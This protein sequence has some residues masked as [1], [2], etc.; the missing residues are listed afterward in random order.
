MVAYLREN[1]GA[2]PSDVAQH[3]GV[4][5]R[6]LR[7]YVRQ[8]NESLDGIAHLGVA[9]GNGYQM[10]VEDEAALDSWL[11]TRTNPRAST[12]PKTPSER[13]IYLLNDLLLRS[14]WVTLGDLSSILYVSKST[15]SRDLQEV[16]RCLGEYGLKLEKRPHHGILV[17]GDEMSRR[18]C[19]ANL[20]LS[21]DSFAALF[22]GGAGSAGDAG[23][24]A[25]TAPAAPAGAR[26]G[27]AWDAGFRET[28]SGILDDVAAC[29]ERA[30]NNQGFQIN[31]AS[32]QNLL[33]HICVAVL[34]I[35]NGYAIPAPVDDMAS[36]LGS[37]EY[38]VAQEI[39][40]SIERTFD[41]ELP[42]EEVAYIAIHLAGKR[43]LDI[44]PAGEGSG[45]EGL[46]ISEE[47]WNVVSRML[48]TVWDIY[49]FDFRNDLELRMNLARHIVPLTVRLR[50]HMDLRNP[51]LADIRVR[52][53]LAYSMAI[54]SSTVLAEE[55]EARLSDDE[56]GYLALAFALAL[57]RLKTE[58]PKKNILMVC[59]SG[60]GSARLLEYR[61]RQ[62]FGAYINQITTC[63]VLNIESIDF[64]DIDYVFTTVP[65]HRQLPVPVREVQ[66]F[67]DVEEVEGVRDFLREN[68]RREPDSILS[69]FDAKLFFPHLPFHTKQEVLDFL[70]ERVA[71]ERDVAPNF[72]EL[73]WKREG[74]VATSFGNNVAMPHPLEPASF[75]TFVCVGVLDQP[76]VWDNL[77][78]TIQV[79]FLSAFAADAGLELQNLYGQLANV[80]VSKQAIAAIVRDQSWETLAA[81]LSTAAEPR[82]IDQM[83]WGEDGAAPES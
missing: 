52:Y 68:A 51:L 77:G 67:L 34:R 38:Q 21:T 64:S 20:A 4:S 30:I 69:Y 74:T 75:E 18:L 66:Y 12:V 73:V 48:D 29:V 28:V 15:L 10:R 11:A 41:L 35:R 72:S 42:V 44:L 55:Y 61:C 2:L 45:D 1:P 22:S 79:V 62:E 26:Q 58:A 46:V 17:T 14:D 81:I 23:S 71:A 24:A 19:L 82:D 54:D 31:S 78:R 59:A 16:E 5:E 25:S 6:T 8:A 76:V 39:A 27:E 33:V 56:V 47:V 63:D 40:D 70:V 3:F 60:A 80:L 49:R 7:M 37:R 65:I 32:Y 43:A 9:R 36:L 53:P 50:Y 57:E 13:V 83:D